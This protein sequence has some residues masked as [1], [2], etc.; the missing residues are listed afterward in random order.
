MHPPIGNSNH[1][2]AVFEVNLS[3]PIY[4]DASAVGLVA[5]DY[6]KADWD[7]INSYVVNCNWNVIFA[8]CADVNQYWNRFLEVVHIAVDIF[9]PTMSSTP[10]NTQRKYPKHIRKL[11][12][13]KK[14]CWA[15]ITV[16]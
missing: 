5:P 1:N 15:M 2:T 16:T 11:L 13:K 4:R 9:V 14:A 12:S 8:D 7:G 10:H 3:L 6:S